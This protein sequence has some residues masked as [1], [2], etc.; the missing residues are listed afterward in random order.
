VAP[1][2]RPRSRTDRGMAAPTTELGIPDSGLGG[3]GVLGGGIPGIAGSGAWR[4][5]QDEWEYVPELRWPLSVRLYDQMRSDSQLAGLLTA[6]MWGISQLRFVVDPNGARPSLVKEV[7]QDLNLPELGKDPEPVGRMKKR[8]SHGRHIV[9][10]M[11]AAIYG[12]YHFEQVGTI[13]DGKWR[14]RKLAPRP[15][16]TLQ[17]INIADDGGLVSIRQW[18]GNMTRM[19]GELVGP[20]LPVDRIVAFIFQQEGLSQ[21]GRSMMRDCYRDYIFK[22]RELRVEAI[23]HERAGGVPYATAPMG[24]STDE[25]NDLDAMMR[26][27]RIG[28]NSGGALPFGAE[29]H[30]AKGS[31][32]D[33]DR[34]IKRIDEAMARRFLLQLVNL[35]QGS[36][37]VGSYSLSQ[38]FEDFFL[39]G[40]RHIAQWYCDTMTAH[41]IE[42]IC[43]L[44][45]GE[46]EELTPQLTW[47]RSTEDSLGTEQLALL[48]QR[49]V[50]T[51]DQELEDWVRYR[52][53]MPKKT[54]P[55]P[56][57]EVTPGG[58]K[59]PTQEQA[60]GEEPGGQPQGDSVEKKTPAK[61]AGD[62]VLPPAP[63]GQ[64]RLEV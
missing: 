40:Q 22:D 56:P 58:P 31:G 64:L 27:F 47:E 39:V 46:E 17:Q 50:I 4:M 11:L 41:V 54:E 18:S 36:S 48:V 20:E 52:Q 12:H 49:G 14:L 19:N 5:Y 51:M 2:G 63:A 15:P 28:E 16:H 57:Q 34:T 26:R 62:G 1:V 32:S 59:Q 30:I 3:M 43:D 29:L 10:A 8:F 23:N 42:D 61:A 33:I 53:R 44:N 21:T 7:C 9:N 35:A 25:I 37:N 24:A 60:L 6:V 38:T 55:R 45:Y 13:V